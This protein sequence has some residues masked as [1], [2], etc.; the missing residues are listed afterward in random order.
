[1]RHFHARSQSLCARNQRLLWPTSAGLRPRIGAQVV[2]PHPP[3]N[4]QENLKASRSWRNPTM[5]HVARMCVICAPESVDFAP[6][7]GGF[8]AVL[9]PESTPSRQFGEK[10]CSRK[11]LST[12]TPLSHDATEVTHGVHS[13]AARKFAPAPGNSLEIPEFPANRACGASASWR[14]PAFAIVPENTWRPRKPPRDGPSAE[15]APNICGIN[16]V[17]QG[18][19]GGSGRIRKSTS[20][21]HLGVSA[22]LFSL[23]HTCIFSYTLVSTSMESS[24][25]RASVGV[26]VA[27]RAV[28]PPVGDHEA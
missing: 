6:E 7:I 1:M 3:G 20:A 10:P 24:D 26:R 13:P 4:S 9:R 8:A 12:R 22:L 14:R 19:F 17:V 11:G 18:F 15:P 23:R 25:L 16:S 21:R 28:D 2:S 27:G 5:R